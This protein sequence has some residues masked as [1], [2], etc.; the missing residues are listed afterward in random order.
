MAERHIIAVMERTYAQRQERFVRLFLA[1]SPQLAWVRK[2]KDLA[3]R[4][5]DICVQTINELVPEQVTDESYGRYTG[6]YEPPVGM[7]LGSA[8][9]KVYPSF[10]SER[11]LNTR[12]AQDPRIRQRITS[13]SS[14]PGFLEVSCG[15]IAYAVSEAHRYFLQQQ[16]LP[17]ELRKQNIYQ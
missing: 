15:E 12:L 16:L 2:D 17:K 13:E 9:V 8:K 1:V 3:A 10:I 14:I 4:I 7:T 11:L 6:S 5:S